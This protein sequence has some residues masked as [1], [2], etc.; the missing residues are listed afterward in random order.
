[1]NNLAG[2]YSALGR[3]A[4]QLA[5]NEKVL[6]LRTEILGERHPNTLTSMNN[7]ALTYRALGRLKDV[8]DL[9]PR[10]VAGAEW[11]RGQPGLSAE[12]RQSLFQGY[13]SGYRKF[14]AVHGS[15]GQVDEGLRLSELGKGRTLLESMTTQRA[16]RSGALPQNEQDALN[17]LNQQIIAHNQLVADAKNSEAEQSFESARNELV[18]KYEALQTSLKARYPKYAQLSDVKVIGLAD[19]PGLVP[20]DG[21]AVSYIVNGTQVSVWLMDSR[22]RPRFVNL[23]EVLNLGDAVEAL[24]RAS[25]YLDG[26]KS[27]LTEDGK[28]VWR[29]PDG[30]YRMLDVGKS[31]P[32]GAVAITD[33][34]EIANYLSAKLLQPLAE[35]LKGKPQWII[36]PDGALAQLPFELLSLDGQRVLERRQIHYTQSLSIYALALAKQRE[37]RGLNRPKDL[38]AMGNPEYQ[39]VSGTAQSRKAMLRDSPIKSVEQLKATKLAWPP[40][41]GTKDEINAV[42]KLFPSNDTFMEAQASEAKLQ[43]LNT[44]GALK[45]YRYLHF[46]VH[47]NLSTADPALSSIVL[48]QVNL[49]EGT[50]G[51][52]TAAKW[53]GYDL[54]SDLTLLSACESG[55][56][57]TISG[58]GVMGLPFA[59]FV[60]GSVNT[61]LTLWPVDDAATA[62]FV[63]AFFAKLKIGQTAAQALTA[64]KR[65]FSKDSRFSN[66]VFWAPFVLVGA[67]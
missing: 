19:L 67:G 8:A 9:S 16:E 63:E 4:E 43:E 23:G 18:R 20:A 40:L 66:P 6:K 2:T 33:V 22:G 56:G 64:T 1:M 60:A 42:R 62:K 51:Y 11:Q 21:V 48:S 65:E 39:N 61:L 30:S 17:G 59:L 13:A 15:L 47:G 3:T 34:A 24:R 31:T 41:P 57:R 37:Y 29:L 25:S 58:E 35:D 38:F 7:L 50:D 32:A 54:R 14:S 53:P 45:N 27:V 12:N 44:T 5:L 52:V 28:R 10:Y 55:L 36:S 46:A 49:K 26:F